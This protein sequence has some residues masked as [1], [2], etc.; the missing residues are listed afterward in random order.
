[1]KYKKVLLSSSFAIALTLTGVAAVQGNASA[2]TTSDTTAAPTEQV[3]QTANTQATATADQG[4]TVQ[5]AELTPATTDA[6]TATTEDANDTTTD[7]TADTQAAATT[8]AD[9]T[10]T[11]DVQAT[12]DASADTTTTPTVAEGSSSTAATKA[13]DT[14]TAPAGTS[15]PTY[16][17]D[18]VGQVL[19][20]ASGVP[21]VGNVVAGTAGLLNS[22]TNKGGKA[23]HDL[24]NN[25][26]SSVSNIP[27]VGSLASGVMKVLQPLDIV[28]NLVGGAYGLVVGKTDAIPDPDNSDGETITPIATNINYTNNQ[29]KKTVTTTEQTPLY[30]QIGVLQSRALGAG[31]DWYTDL[32][33]TNNNT[34]TTYYRVSTDEYVN[35]NDVT[36][37]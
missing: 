16:D 36:I 32:Q 10:Q 8:S 34:G 1:M 5:A 6:A 35:A 3:A 18:K 7:A 22:T 31:T 20:D 25:V 27:L 30:D 2:D 11:A 28:D 14:T 4:A 24:Q 33:R 23:V 29:I 21:I 9:A 15:N 12:T 19:L 17:V 26:I 37:S 13:G